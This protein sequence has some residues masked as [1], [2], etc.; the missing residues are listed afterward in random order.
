MRIAPGTAPA[1]TS[2]RVPWV[3]LAVALGTLAGG[4]SAFDLEEDRVLLERQVLLRFRNDRGGPARALAYRIRFTSP[5]P[6]CR[7]QCDGTTPDGEVACPWPT[8][9]PSEAVDAELD[10][11][12]PWTTCREFRN[13]VRDVRASR[14]GAAHYP[15]FLT[16]ACTGEG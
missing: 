4:C 6:Q 2:R 16:V 1:H 12:A 10:L 11:T 8:A 15:M 14:A 5:D 7:W 13:R 9:C 3:A